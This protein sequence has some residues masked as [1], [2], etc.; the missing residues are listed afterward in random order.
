MSTQQ[1]ATLDK[2][3]DDCLANFMIKG[4]IGLTAGLAISLLFKRKAFPI[5][6]SL[7]FGLG[8]AQN[9]CQ[10]NYDKITNELNKQ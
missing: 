3:F 4:A 7:G 8:I 9:Q 2:T 1:R 6:G 10:S 5:V